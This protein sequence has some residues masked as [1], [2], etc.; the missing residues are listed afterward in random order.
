MDVKILGGKSFSFLKVKLSPG[1]E[2]TSEAGAMAS[3]DKGISLKTILNGSFLQALL[4][5]FLGRETIFINKFKNSTNTDQ[6][7]YLTQPVP[8]QIQEAELKGESLFIQAGAYIASTPGITFSLRWAGFSSWFAREGL[9]RIQISGRGKVWYGSFGAVVTREVNGEY[10]VDTG[11]LLSYPPNMKLS[12]KL[13]G[14]LFSSFFGGEGFVLKL[15]GKGT[16]QLQTRSIE[17]LAGWLNP[18]FWG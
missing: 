13:A 14:G 5:K 12:I 17:G 1:D 3:M 15:S 6:T 8:G 11:H 2:I 4:I 9:F 18:K 16:I 7:I 10:I